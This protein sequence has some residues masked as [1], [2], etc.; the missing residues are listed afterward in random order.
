[1]DKWNGDGRLLSNR[2]SLAEKPQRHI[3]KEGQSSWFSVYCANLSSA[4]APTSTLAKAKMVPTDLCVKGI[5]ARTE[6]F[7]HRLPS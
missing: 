4:L 5:S 1:M 7:K 3:F 2:D 6:P